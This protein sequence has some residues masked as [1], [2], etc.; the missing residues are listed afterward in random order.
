MYI[1]IDEFSV[2]LRPTSHLSTKSRVPVP[3]TSQHFLS[4]GSPYAYRLDLVLA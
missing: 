4:S 1:M 3:Y 2:L